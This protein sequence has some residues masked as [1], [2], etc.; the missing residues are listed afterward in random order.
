M[1]RIRIFALGIVS[2]FAVLMGALLAPGTF[3]NRA[4]SAALCTVFSFSST[5]CTVNLAKSSD[6]VVA[7]TPP[8][9]EKN[10]LDWL[11]QRDPGEFDDAPS[12]PPG[13]NPQAP[14]FPQDPGP[15]QPVRP[16]FD[17]PGSGQPNNPLG[18]CS[19]TGKWVY[20]L[21]AE[22]SDNALISSIPIEINQDG[23][24]VNMRKNL[25]N[26]L[27]RK[28]S[29]QQLISSKNGRTTTEKVQDLTINTTTLK[30]GQIMWGEIRDIKEGS[31]YFL[32][33]RQTPCVPYSPISELPNFNHNPYAKITDSFV[34]LAV[35]SIDN[36]SETTENNPKLAS[37]SIDDFSE[38]TEDSQYRS[39]IR[40]INVKVAVSEMDVQG[41][42]LLSRPEFKLK[43]VSS[44]GGCYRSDRQTQPNRNIN[45][46]QNGSKV[47]VDGVIG[48]IRRPDGSLVVETYSDGSS[49]SP[50][51][52]R[53]GKFNLLERSAIIP[54]AGIKSLL[55]Y[56]GNVVLYSPPPKRPCRIMGQVSCS[57]GQN[58]STATG[59]FSLTRQGVTCSD[60]RDDSYVPSQ[61]N[62]STNSEANKPRSEVNKLLASAAD[63]ARK[64]PESIEITANVMAAGIA[65][66]VVFGGAWAL[67]VGGGAATAGVGG[68]AATAEVAGITEASQLA[69]AAARLQRLMT[70]AETV[71]K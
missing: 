55:T 51:S 44:G 26:S 12:A 57:F 41:T 68:A 42:W 62:Q 1:R 70:V 27:P 71:A 16:E 67:G 52:I 9:V 65:L 46:R 64:H 25:T 18:N 24:K 50:G 13:S 56:E 5:L 38:K 30:D 8:A 28:Q 29:L 3:V 33:E 54:K 2:F 48:K 34:K 32:L 7:A 66:A 39:N 21:Y 69:T 49:S 15:N 37:A 61:N 40:K 17:N 4:L 45:I 22:P 63:F 43:V 23:N 47:F 35:A 36:F 14:P 59:A 10:I 60:S 6:R 11:V 58:Q 20:S 53:S 31:L 19:L